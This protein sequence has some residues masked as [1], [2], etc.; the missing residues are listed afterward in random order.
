[1]KKPFSKKTPTLGGGGGGGRGITLSRVPVDRGV[2]KSVVPA[3]Q[4]LTQGQELRR[5]ITLK[6][7]GEKCG[8]PSGP[9]AV[10]ILIAP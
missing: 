6:C 1:V 9:A 8:G 5:P 7:C 4:S 2:R 10:Q 3:L